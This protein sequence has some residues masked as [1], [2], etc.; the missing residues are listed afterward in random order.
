MDEKA[1]AR[2]TKTMVCT[3]AAVDSVLFMRDP[4]PVFNV[5]NLLQGIEPNTRLIVFAGKLQLAQGEAP[6]SVVVN[7]V[8]SNNQS[9]DVPAE[10]VRPVPNFDFTEVI[11]RLP[12]NLPLGTCTIQLKL[13]GLTSNSGTFRI[14]I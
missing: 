6:S 13:H 4:F 2:V 3:V 8:D 10:E 7:I 11:F 5:L 1:S 12:N 14:R 9:Q